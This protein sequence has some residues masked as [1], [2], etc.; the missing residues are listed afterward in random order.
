MTR[1]VEVPVRIPTG[2]DAEPAFE[3]PPRGSTSPTR[4]GLRTSRLSDFMTDRLADFFR[5]QPYS[6]SPPLRVPAEGVASPPPPFSQIGRADGYSS[7]W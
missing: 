4:C 1:P 7:R 6:L 2:A 5:P 3:A